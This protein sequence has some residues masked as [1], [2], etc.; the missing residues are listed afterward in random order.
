MSDD[1]K[2]R[3][4]ATLE[5]ALRAIRE[6]EQT[7]GAWP[8]RKLRIGEKRVVIPAKR[9]SRSLTAPPQ[10]RNNGRRY[11]HPIHD[12]V[13]EAVPKLVQRFQEAGFRA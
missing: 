4:Y 9:Q 11:Y 7:S 8:I 1:P 5:E 10:N 3:G 2:P 13:R 6:H 12:H